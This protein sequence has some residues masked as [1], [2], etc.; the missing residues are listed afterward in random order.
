MLLTDIEKGGSGAQPASDRRDH[1]RGS[2]QVR[3]HQEH[4]RGSVGVRERVGH[5]REHGER[6]GGT[7]PCGTRA[8]GEPA[9]PRS[10]D[11][12]VGVAAV[13]AAVAGAVA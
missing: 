13:V 12:P 2:D 4:L 9:Q 6:H 7:D 10:S 1:D 3:H 11:P 8:A 5:Q